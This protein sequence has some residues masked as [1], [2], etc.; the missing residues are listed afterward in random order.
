VSPEVIFDQGQG[1]IFVVRVAG[2]V[3]GDYEIASLEY[4]IQQLGVSLVLVM[5]HAKCGAVK[6]AM[7]SGVVHGPI[8][9]LLHQ[10]YPAVDQARKLE[11]DLLDHAIRLHVI[12]SAQ[13]LIERSVV[14]SEAVER[15]TLRVIGLVYDLATG[16]LEIRHTIG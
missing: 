5:G 1:D 6:S 15:G 11:G 13:S 14:M 7:G 10:I 16:D 9:R 2:H 4:A 3:A 8:G 12:A